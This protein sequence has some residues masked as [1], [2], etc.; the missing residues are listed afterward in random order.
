MQLRVRHGGGVRIQKQKKIFFVGDFPDPH[1]LSLSSS[2]TDDEDD[3]IAMR[4][5]ALR[6]NEGF[7]QKRQRVR[8]RVLMFFDRCWHRAHDADGY[9]L[10]LL[11]L[12]RASERER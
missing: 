12:L 11:L 3:A 7:R 9:R 2:S 8:V 10:L 6:K 1:S 5:K 4:H